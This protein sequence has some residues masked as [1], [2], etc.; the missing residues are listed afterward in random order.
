MMIMKTAFI[1]L[2]KTIQSTS[3]RYSEEKE[4]AFDN[5]LRDKQN[6]TL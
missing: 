5:F 1:K 6:R 3:K 2:Q 4:L